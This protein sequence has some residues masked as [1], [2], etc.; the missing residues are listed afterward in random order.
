MFDGSETSMSGNG[1]FMEH[2]GTNGALGALFIPSGEG[3]GC[4]E[5]GPFKK[6]GQTPFSMPSQDLLLTILAA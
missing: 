5:S 3:G 1:E 4:V 2:N 6:Y